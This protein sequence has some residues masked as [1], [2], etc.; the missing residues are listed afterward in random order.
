MKMVQVEFERKVRGGV[1]RTTA[2]VDQSWH[3]KPGKIVEFE[4]DEVKVFTPRWTVV[5]VGTIVQEYREIYRK[6]NVGGL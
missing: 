3:L 1:R 4:D 2:W 6:W 5:K